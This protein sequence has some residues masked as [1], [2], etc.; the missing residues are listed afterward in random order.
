MRSPRSRRLIQV[1]LHALKPDTTDTDTADLTF[2]SAFPPI[3]EP[4]HVHRGGD[5]LMLDASRFAQVGSWEGVIRLDGEEIQVTPDTWI[6][7]RDRSWGIRPVGEQPPAG[8][9]PCDEGGGEFAGQLAG[10]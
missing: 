4:H 10:I 2:Q 3:E 8:R 6:A 1:S 9:P 7:T 5:K